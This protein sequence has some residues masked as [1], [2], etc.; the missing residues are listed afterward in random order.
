MDKKLWLLF[1]LILVLGIFSGMFIQSQRSAGEQETFEQKV[2]ASSSGLLAP[3]ETA[4]V[5]DFNI[6]VHDSYFSSQQEKQV[7]V[8][9]ISF[10]N[11]AEQPREIPLFNILVTDA[12]GHT[13]ENLTSYDDQRLVG[14]QI[15]A[16]GLRRGTLAFDVGDSNHYELSYTNHS[17]N[18]LA[19]WN[20]KPSGSTSGGS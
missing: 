14:G 1:G 9:D 13:Y 5:G 12:D 17:G 10:Q 16:G 4:E 18:G 11:L 20:L 2:S 7:L 19:A 15:R 6:T 8:A 3:G